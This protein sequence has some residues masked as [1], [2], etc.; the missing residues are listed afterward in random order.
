MASP[1]AVTTPSKSTAVGANALS[2][3]VAE[4]AEN[5]GVGEAAG[6]ALT[7]SG[8]YDNTFVGKD[9]WQDITGVA[10][11]NSWCMHNTSMTVN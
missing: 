5:T 9:Y 2:Y 8:T 7:D 11:N 4:G 6:E 10:R 3:N 1:D